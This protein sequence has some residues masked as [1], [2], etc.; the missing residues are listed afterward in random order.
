MS[1][2]VD[3]YVAA[4]RTSLKENESLKALNRELADAAAEPVAVVGM[5]CRLP[6]GI[7]SPEDFWA[8]LD[9]GTDAAGPAPVDRGWPD[10]AATGGFLPDAGQFDADLFGISPREALA[11]DPQQRLLLETAW[12]TVERAGMNPLSLRGTRTGVYI[13]SSTSAYGIA[14][15]ATEDVEGYL[16]T[17]SAPSVLSGRVAY[18][19]GLEGPAITIDTACSSSLVALHLAAQALRRGECTLALA[20]GVTVMASPGAF[21]EFGRQGGLAADGTGWAEGVAVLLVERLSDARRNGHTVLALLRGSAVNSD[22]ASNGLTAPNGPAQ[23]RVIADALAAAGLAP[24]EV[25]A[26]EAHGTGT[27]LGDP[28]EAGAVLAAYGQDR[29]RPLWLGSVKSNLGHAQSAA[30]AAGVIKMILA[31]RNEMLP[32]TLHVDRPSP[33]VDWDSGAVSLLTDAQ[34]WPRGDR[35][36]RAG[37]SAFGV[38]GTNAHVII[39]QAPAAGPTGRTAPTAR[40]PWVLAGK[41]AEA[42]RAQADRLRTGLDQDADP[43]DIAFSLATTRAALEHRAV[44]PAGDRDALRAIALGEPH[45]GVVTGTVAPGG[46]AVLFTGQGAQRAGMGRGLAAAFPVFAAAI[47]EITA[48]LGDIPFDDAESL[49]QTRHTQAA[50]FAFE[51]ALYRLLESWGVRPKYLVGHSIGEVAAAHVAGVLSL[52]DA[53]TLVAARGRLM[54]DLPAGGAMLA[55]EVSESDV[56]AGIDIAAVNGPASLVVSGTED[57]IEAL[58]DRWRAD[59]R[60]VKRL[61]VSHAFHSRLMEPMLAEFAETIRTLTFHQPNVRVVAGGDVTDPGYWVRQVRDTVRFADA[62]DRLA[63]ADV[64]AWAE[65]GPDAVLSALVDGAVPLQRSGRDEVDAWWLGLARLHVAGVDVDWSAA[66]GNRVDLPAYAFQ[67]EHYWLLP[68]AAPAATTA[69]EDAWRYRVGWRPLAD[70]GPAVLSGTWLVVSRPGFDAAPYLEALTGR[71]ATVRHTAFP[72]LPDEP[73]DGVLSLLALD[74][75]DA[76]ADTVALVNALDSTATPLWV[77]TRGAVAIGGESPDPVAAGLWGLGRVAALEFPTRWG[78]L[79]DL[80]ADLDTAAADRLARVLTGTGE[81]QVAIRSGGAFGRRLE[82]APARPATPW[83]PRGTV[84]VTGGTGALGG[85]VARWLAGRGAERLL[86]AS[87]RGPAAPGAAELIAEL[88]D[89]G[90]DVT[91]VACDTADRDAIAA[92]LADHPVAAVVHAAGWAE[93]A[94][95]PDVTPE[96]LAAVAAAKVAGAVHLDELLPDAEAFVLFSSVAGVWGGG[97]QAAYAAAN[98]TLDAIAAARRARG[99]AATSVAWGPWAGAGMVAAGAT[100]DY[101]RERGLRPM[102]PASAVAALAS[103]VD[104]GDTCV[105]VA[106]VDWERFAGAFTATRP[107]ALLANLPAARGHAAVAVTPTGFAATL[108]GLDAAD[109]ARTVLDLVRAKAAA[110]LGHADASRVD[111]VRPFRD[112]GFDSLTAV[113]LRTALAEATGLALPSTLV[114]DHPTPTVLAGHLVAKL[115]GAA[116]EQASATVVANGDPLAIVAMACRYPGGVSSPDDLWRLVMSCGDGMGPFPADRG[117]DMSGPDAPTARVG[118]FVDGAAE[119]DAGLFGISPRE[120]VAMD[121]QQRLHL[122]ASW[123]VFERAGVDPTSLRGSR[124]GVFAGTSGQDYVSLL[125]AASGYLATGGSAS[126]VSGRVSYV[127]GLEG[128]SVSVDTACSSSLVALHLAAQSLRR[129]ECDL[130]LAGGVVVMATPAAYVEFGKQNGVAA[131][132]RCKSFAAAAD[133]TGWSEGVGVLLVERLSDARRNGHDVLAVLRGSAINSDGASNGLTAPNGPSQ[134]RVIRAALADAGLEPSDVDMV[135]AHGTGT[136]LGDPI[137]AQALLATYGQDRDEPLWLG[138]IKSNIGHSQAASGVAGV[139][140]AV[141]ALRHGQLPPTLNVDA[142]TPEVDW[143][144]GNVELLT[145]ARPWPA[146]GRPRRAGVSSFGMSGTNAHVVVEEAPA[147]DPVDPPAMTGPAD[148]PWPVSARTAAGVA[149][150][151]ERLRAWAAGRAGL[152]PVDVGLALGTTRAA[153]AHRAV[154][155][156]AGAGLSQAGAATGGRTA[157][158]FTGQGAQRAGMGRELYAAFPVFAQAWDAVAD[159]V[160]GVPLDDADVLNRTDGAQSA[161]FAV[162]V[163]LFRLLESWGMAPDFLLGHSIGELAAAHVAGV[164]SLDDACALVAARGRLMAALPAGGAMLAVEAAE[165]DVPQGIDLAAV[166]SP[167]SLVVS[168]AEDEIGALEDRW[169][170]E[171]RRVKRLVVSHAFHSRLMEPMLADFAAV[172]ESVTYHEPRIAMPGDVTDPAYWVRQVRGTVRFADGVAWLRDHGVTAFVELGPDPVL[173]AHVDG[174]VPTLRKGRDETTTVLSAAASAWTHGAGLDWAALFATWDA[175]RT[176]VPTYAFERARYWAGGQTPLLGSETPLAAGGVVLSGRLSTAF[177]PW[178]SDHRILDRVV[179]PGTAL[180]EMA[181]RAAARADRPAI[182]ELTLHTPLAL[183]ERGAVQVQVSVAADDT[184]EIHARPDDDTAAWTRHASGL[185]ADAPAPE[186]LD[187]D[188]W[189]PTDAVPLDLTG[190]YDRLG[191]VGLEYGPAFRGL[192][193][194]WRHGDDVLAE[195]AL[196]EENRHD[197]GAFGLHPA[198]LD[199]A[200]HAVGAGGLFSD[201]A[202]LPFSW[203]GVALHATGAAMLR[204]RLT[205][206]GQDSLRLKATD[207]AGATVAVVDSLTVRAPAA[208]PADRGPLDALFAVEWTPAVMA[209]TA[210]GAALPDVADLPAGSVRDVVH[211]ALDLVR[212]RLAGHG[213]DPLVIRTRGAV[214]ARPGDTVTDLGAAGAWGLVRSAQ[215]EHPGR[216]VLVDGDAPATVLAAVVASGEPQAAVRGADVLVPRLARAATLPV[217]AIPAEDTW[218]LAP[219][220]DGTLDGLDLIPAEPEPLAAGHV[221]IA[222]RAAGIN[223]RD[224]LIALGSYPEAAAMGTEAAGVVLAVGD[225]VADLRPGD[226]VFGLVSGGF[227]PV[228]TADRRHLAPIPAGWSFARAASIPM[229][230]LT[231]YYGLVDLAGLRA[232]ESV[233]IHAA[234]GG[235]GTAAVQ[236]ARHLGA[237]VYGTASPAKWPA[238]GLAADH[239]AS[240]RDLGFAD[241]FPKVDVVLNA[242]AGEFVDASLGLLAPGGRFIEMGKAD[243]RSPEGV[244]YRAFDLGEAGPDRTRDMLA[245]L[246]ALFASGALTP[247]PVRAWDIREAAT[248]FRHIGQGRHTGKNVFT[249]PRP[250]DPDGTVLITGGTGALGTAVAEHLATRHGARHLL[251]ASRGGKGGPNQETLPGTDIRVVACDLTDRVALAGLLAGIPAE[252]PLTAVIHAAGVLDDGVVEAVTPDRLD[253]VMAPKADA[254]IAL[255]ELTADADLAVFALYSSASAVFGTPGQ[256]NYAA[257]NAVLDGLAQR[258]RADGLPATA[259]AWGMWEGGMTGSLS[260]HDRA[261]GGTAITAAQ[262]TALFDAATGLAQAYV[263]PA[264]LDLAGLRSAG[265]PV[266]PLLRGLV[267]PA[268]RAAARETAGGL[269]DQLARLPGAE[270]TR[271]ALDLVLANTALVLGHPSPDSVGPDRPF[272]DLGVDS[273]TAVELR[274]RLAAAAGVRLPATLVFDHP[275][276]SALAAFLLAEAVP[277]G[278]APAETALAGLERV[279]VLLP[280]MDAP[281]VAAVRARMEALLAK[282]VPA[283]ADGPGADRDLTDATTDTIFDLIDG[284][285]TD[286]DYADDLVSQT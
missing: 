95:L 44:V 284:E 49:G 86:L 239:L 129:G 174:A 171:G 17:G 273:L 216:F 53:C 277:A 85:H 121:P 252:H 197:P 230:Y 142:P 217:L 189:P 202:R 155:S 110:V 66:G 272:T 281:G 22:G 152:R 241:R 32:R 112:L 234:A 166:N 116:A 114:F 144:A 212:A 67:R 10:A 168:G 33:H 15:A 184:L 147:A 236:L 246:L 88:T 221:R 58:A 249:L 160:G 143:T 63:D 214:A 157:F 41:T 38:S 222:V 137:E 231:A 176:E 146:V 98:A 228:A 120:A 9:A 247:P 258:R 23:Q 190:L 82:P 46:L 2:T 19:L 201:G 172:A 6:G 21:V 233:L 71:G 164:L 77:A 107:S 223:F 219:P 148:V 7:A 215:T 29:D 163:A 74:G 250:I 90:V 162:E 127:F 109:R 89:L 181:L 173:C 79:V 203:S 269:A 102:E 104:G 64:G 274:N 134:Q 140:K 285:L 179:V 218:H 153:L 26:V 150:Q 39:E 199:A 167:T 271:I 83:Q 191:S 244:T 279:A 209:D 188:A 108:R 178:L 139:I 280:G 105:A 132:G 30:G 135:E 5:A 206:T 224:V 76:L 60:R 75:A 59:G 80:P 196:P 286:G 68:A 91:V 138:S 25:D 36:R 210:P 177:Q 87:R 245:D 106:D 211:H 256:A 205:R 240:S 242:L 192:R 111:P 268:P 275:T 13:G 213:A 124:T 131:D 264:N 28:I 169:R 183:P 115:T 170:A 207:A 251:L 145:E 182:A 57:E 42:L 194:A 65:V 186:G 198:L 50:L 193:A 149:A 175:R 48:R 226:R 248:A 266:P 81:D 263:V 257:A 103:A 16:G 27:V 118:G 237:E 255:H 62:V 260:D 276:P 122:E 84:L 282:W 61:A 262:G 55:A 52:D 238:T 3:Q 56:P 35:V 72:D 125:P 51:V 24:S 101:L 227:G 283:D 187:L 225:G 180:L 161:L 97:G 128:P 1:A 93:Y 270:R 220:A 8:L 200:V 70:S 243:L 232:G 113:E 136:R 126:V 11:M 185:V 235:V 14:T 159:R 4:L 78:G 133:G 253:A 69:P 34:P 73:V 229:A 204:V 119:F 47:G 100:A 265:A 18:A 259:L 96:H 130:A 99:A 94:A 254:A 45:P 141:M 151:A 261:R 267:R 156:S 154:L 158:L 165:D 123:E 117:W 208:P 278:P 31:L 12:E 40:I 20:G 37:V 54:Q 195:V 43:A 92:L